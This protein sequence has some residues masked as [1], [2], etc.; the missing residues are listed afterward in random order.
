MKL[1]IVLI[2]LCFT[3]F[4]ANGQ[5]KVGSVDS[6]LIVGLMPESKIVLT[7]LN[8]Y[9]KRLDSSYQVKVDDYQAKVA[10]FKK[11]DPSLSDNF[12]K[13]KVDEI[14]ELERGLQQSQDNGNK[15]IQL[16]RNELM[17]PLYKILRDK[18]AEVA[19]AESYTQILTTTGNEFAYID[20]N[21]DITKKVMAKLGLKM[22]P[23]PAKK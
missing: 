5:T 2:A 9:A 6:E 7:K 1:K 17:R 20:V 8:E 18:I 11:L 23:P 16:K 4:F 12:K 15:L 21:F 19:K 3:G 14:T 13:I 10:A 22:P